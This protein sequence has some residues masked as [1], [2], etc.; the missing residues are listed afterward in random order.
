MYAL[1]EILKHKDW[2]VHCGTRE[3]AVSLLKELSTRGFTWVNGTRYSLRNNWDVYTYNT[4][5]YVAEGTFAN[6]DYA[7]EECDTIVEFAEVLFHQ[8]QQPVSISMTFE[9]VFGG[10]IDD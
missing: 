5:Y 9:D 6:L 1:D 4:V 8:S 7:I 10:M 3:D 2:C